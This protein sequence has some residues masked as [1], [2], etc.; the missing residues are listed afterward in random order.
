MALF[1]FIAYLSFI[2]A[3]VIWMLLAVS[4][5]IAPGCAVNS[6]WVRATCFFLPTWRFFA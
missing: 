5:A 1:I 2:A 6:E 4:Y 3:V